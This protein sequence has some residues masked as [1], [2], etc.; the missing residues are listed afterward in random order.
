MEISVAASEKEEIVL[1]SS[2][3]QALFAGTAG[4]NEGQS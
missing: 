3:E 1:P 2:G 4:K